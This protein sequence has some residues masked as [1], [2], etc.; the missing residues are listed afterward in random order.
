M[1]TNTI[2]ISILMVAISSTFLATD[3]FIPSLPIIKSFFGVT[4]ETMGLTLSLNLLGFAISAPFY[5]P[6]SDCYGRRP[7]MLIGMAVFLLGSLVCAFVPSFEMLIIGRFFQGIGA[8]VAGVITFA[9][10]KDLYT[11]KKCAQIISSMDMVIVIIPAIGPIIGAYIIEFMGW[12]ANFVIIAIISV[13]AFLLLVI[14]MPE[15]HPPET[16]HFFKDL[17]FLKIYHA[18]FASFPFMCYVL[19]SATI[20]GGLWVLIAG[21]PYLIIELFGFTVVGYAYYCA[22]GVVAYII[23]A[24]VNRFLIP[25]YGIDALLWFGLM[26]S[27]VTGFTS[28]LVAYF[29]PDSP[30]ILRVTTAFYTFAMAFVFSNAPAKALAVFPRLSGSSSSVMTSVEMA[31]AALAS[32][33]TSILYDDSMMSLALLMMIFSLVAY[34]LHYLLRVHLSTATKG[35]TAS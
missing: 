28:I 12:Q 22:V 11:I 7:L 3:L 2:T 18:L 9:V 29:T 1:K 34:G 13:I 14:Q 17:S 27:V 5:G 15:S 19:V 8:S 20:W 33:L 31:V 23:G 32:F 30:Y 24:A 10:I 21:T 16:R 4:D 26:F 25:K 6:L 35:E